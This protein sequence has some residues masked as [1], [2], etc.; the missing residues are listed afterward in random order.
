MRDFRA[1]NLSKTTRLPCR[2]SCYLCITNESIM[3]SDLLIRRLA[4]EILF[5]WTLTFT[6][7]LLAFV[8]SVFICKIVCCFLTSVTF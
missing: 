1:K 4:M 7:A 6:A 8:T 5:H 2:K 3:H